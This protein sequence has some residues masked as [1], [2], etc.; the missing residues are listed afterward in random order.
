MSDVDYFMQ[1]YLEPAIQKM[2]HDWFNREP[3]VIAPE[4]YEHPDAAIARMMLESQ[5]TQ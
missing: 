4:G 5:E 3:N 2:V 1:H